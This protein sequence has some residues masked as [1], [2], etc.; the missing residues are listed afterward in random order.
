MTDR[1]DNSRG[2]EM[3]SEQIMKLKHLVEALAAKD[4]ATIDSPWLDLTSAARYTTISSVHI[5]R[6][7]ASGKIRASR[8]DPQ[9]KRSK[10]IFF[11]PHLDQFLH[12]GHNRRLSK[13]EKAELLNRMTR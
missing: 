7:V 9:N 10:L 2:I 3:M 8:I 1:E 12:L 11:K 4:P 6:L 5:R 13:A